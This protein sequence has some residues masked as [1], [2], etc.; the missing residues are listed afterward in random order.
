LEKELAP[1][2]GDS[3]PILRPLSARGKTNEKPANGGPLTGLSALLTRRTVVPSEGLAVTDILRPAEGGRQASGAPPLL[4][5][6]VRVADA[7]VLAA[8][9]LVDEFAIIGVAG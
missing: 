6:A 5:H 8:A 3:A 4:V 1:P 7:V 9:V 2:E